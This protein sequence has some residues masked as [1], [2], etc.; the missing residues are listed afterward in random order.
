MTKQLL[1]SAA[2]AILAFSASAETKVLWGTDIPEGVEATWGNPLLSL[3]AEQAATINP[4]DIL[5]MKVESASTEGWPQ[6]A[7]FE[8]GLGWPPMSNVGV[9]G[10]TY[11]FVATFPVTNDMAATFKASGVDF[12]GDGAFVSEISQIEGPGYLDPNAIWFGHETLAWGTAISIPNSVFENVKPGDKIQVVYDT[13]APEH[14]L[15]IILG[16]WSGLNLATYEAGSHDFMT[17]DEA[18]GV[19]TIELTSALSSY[20]W[21]EKT[22]DAFTLLKENGL[23]M[24]GPCTVN[25]ILY[26]QG[27]E[28]TV[29]YYAVGGFQGWNVEEPAQFT[30]A[31]GVYTL[32][33]EGASTMK[34]STLAGDWDSFNSAT[35]APSGEAADGVMPFEVKA[36]YEF[37]LDYLANWTVTIDNSKKTIKFTTNDARPEVDVYLRG[38]MNT[39]EAVDE[40]KFTTTDGNVFTLDNVSIEA[41]VQFKVADSSWGTVNYGT[42]EAIAPNTTVTLTYNGSNCVLTE[43]VENATVEFNLTDKTFKV[44]TGSGIEAIGSENASAVYYNLQGVKVANPAEGNVYIVKKGSKVSKVAF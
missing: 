27:S 32:V 15:Q 2:V 33:A 43:S 31:D 4:G 24:Q 1:A 41:G 26:V 42:S 28:E 20:E 39:W 5:T 14:T 37:V 18:T 3:T 8:G 30:F 36:D 40:W 35:I 38:G 9:G 16:G 44:V 34:I 21:S 12:K 19:I 22:Y 25:Q 7:I 17:I 13:A 23:V 10:K 29:N 11:P 6:V